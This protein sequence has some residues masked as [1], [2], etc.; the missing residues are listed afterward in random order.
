MKACPGRKGDYFE[1]FAEID[2]LAALSTCPGGD[3]SINLFGDHDP[4]ECCRPIGVE[5]KKVSSD[6]LQSRAW[7]SPQMANTQYAGCHG[8]KAPEWIGR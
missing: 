1:F 3:L 4:V 6:I 2:L 7:H 5:V 8:L